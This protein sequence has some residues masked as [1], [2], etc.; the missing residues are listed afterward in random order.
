MESDSLFTT[1]MQVHRQTIIDK[2]LEGVEETRPGQYDLDVLRQNGQL[3]MKLLIDIH[4]P[5]EDH[6]L[7][8]IIPRMC[9]YH[10][11]R[12]TPITDL[13]HSS[14]LWRRS[15]IETIH[16]LIDEHWIG[17]HETIP[18]MFALHT[19]IDHVQKLI[20]HFYWEHAEAQLQQK[21]ATIT[22]LHDDRLNML[23]KMAAS[24]AHELRNPLFAIEGFL[25]L[26]RTELSLDTLG[27]VSPYLDIIDQEFTGLYRQITAFL[28]FSR[29][30]KM[31]EPMM[32]CQCDDLI[33]S[34]LSI[35][36]PRSINE[37][38]EIIVTYH[39]NPRLLMQKVGLQQ[40]LSNL[41]NNS[42]DAL[43]DVKGSK[44]IQLI[45]HEDEHHVFISVKDNGPG[46]P[47]TLKPNV[48][49]P[50]VTSKQN[51]TGLGLAICKQI[52][53][54]NNGDITF[55]SSPGETIFTLSLAKQQ[56][57]GHELG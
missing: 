27:R 3:Y 22:K 24:M 20:S 14:H 25:K 16:T 39:A 33:D 31:E 48:F 55:K 6:P 32:E 19:R 42:M 23:G 51:G 29:N 56:Q 18:F 53:E 54:K 30:E 8:S 10:A 41:M 11:E 17:N 1:L 4:I 5:V 35:I 37:N 43:C 36:H 47:D 46:I 44:T 50:F 2:W 7:F 26:I 12:K 9:Q 28:S 57:N 52:M 45:C 13:L 21:D 40:V 34:V 38:V 15:I 49:T